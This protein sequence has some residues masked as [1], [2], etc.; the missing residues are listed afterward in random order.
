MSTPDPAQPPIGVAPPAA[1]VAP[2]AP[3]PPAPASAAPA[4]IVPAEPFD[5]AR[6]LA[7][8]AAQRASETALKAQLA[9]A[10]KAQDEL[11]TIKAAQLTDQE[12][13]AAELERLKAAAADGATALREARLL[14][15]LAK[16]DVGLVDASA[17]AALITGVTYDEAGSPTNLDER[18][19]ALKTERPFLLAAPTSPPAP[20]VPGINPGGGHQPGPAPT[21]TVEEAQQAQSAG[22]DPAT[23]AAL[24]EI[25]TA[26]NQYE[27][28]QALRAQ[29]KAPPA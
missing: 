25:G 12:K 5:E 11:A 29:R 18:I 2:P 8:I 9:E 22:M 13:Q 20:V 4:P 27:A 1:P 17:A 6:A 10:K 3:A 28:W 24:K 15:A 26:S 21:L 14:A 16:P 23:F 19:T 7:T